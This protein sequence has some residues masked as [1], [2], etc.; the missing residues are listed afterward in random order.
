VRPPGSIDCSRALQDK[1][2]LAL[3]GD[4]TFYSK[5]EVLDA[6]YG[7]NPVSYKFFIRIRPAKMSGH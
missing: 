6:V 3:G 5:P 4:L 7:N 2:S 1:F